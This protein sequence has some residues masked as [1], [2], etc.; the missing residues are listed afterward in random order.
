VNSGGERSLVHI[1][2][3]FF[4]FSNNTAPTLDAK[5]PLPTTVQQTP[6][7]CHENQSKTKNKRRRRAKRQHPQS[8]NQ[9]TN[10]PTN[11]HLTGNAQQGASQERRVGQETLHHGEGVQILGVGCT[12]LVRVPGH[13]LWLLLL[14]LL[15]RRR[16]R[17][18]ASCCGNIRYSA[19]R[20]FRFAPTGGQ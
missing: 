10:Q 17:L 9:P 2:L 6:E 11:Q 1:E 14:L 3:L 18:C 16:Q 15:R 19:S 13:L 20:G 12:D 5:T 8:I 4:F 7:Q